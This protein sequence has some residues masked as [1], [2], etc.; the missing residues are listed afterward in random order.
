MTPDER[1]ALVVLAAGATTRDRVASDLQI[2][3]HQAGEVINS[4]IRQS[5]VVRVQGGSSRPEYGVTVRG[6]ATAEQ[7]T[8]GYAPEAS[9]A[10]QIA[11]VRP[12]QV[13]RPRRSVRRRAK[14]QAEE[15]PDYE[16]RRKLLA[17]LLGGSRTRDQLALELGLSDQATGRLLDKAI[18]DSTVAKLS[19]ASDGHRYCLTVE[20]RKKLL[21][22][23]ERL[24]ELARKPTT[25][26]NDIA[27]KQPPPPPPAPAKWQWNPELTRPSDWRWNWRWAAIVVVAVLILLVLSRSI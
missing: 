12:E 23:S 15:K 21:G 11:M 16:V 1:V 20:G 2:P 6:M 7:F 10:Y 24:Q 27:P 9:L 22:V 25:P 18:R 17:A 19:R 26:T 5:L 14:A 4:L 3:E 13:R 8:A